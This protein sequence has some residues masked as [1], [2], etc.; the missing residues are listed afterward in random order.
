MSNTDQIFSQINGEGAG[1]W[2]RRRADRRSRRESRRVASGS[3]PCAPTVS[4]E[5]DVSLP[6][7]GRKRSARNGRSLGPA[8]KARRSSI[9]PPIEDCVAHRT[10]S[11]SLNGSELLKP[12]VSEDKP[13]STE[14]NTPALLARPSSSKSG[15]GFEGLLFPFDDRDFDYSPFSNSTA[16]ELV[17]S[18]HSLYSPNKSKTRNRRRKTKGGNSNAGSKRQRYELSS[19]TASISSLQAI[20]EA[21]AARSAPST[22]RPVAR[23]TLVFKSSPGS[24][25]NKTYP[26]R[27]RNKNAS[28]TSEER[29]RD[30]S[31]KR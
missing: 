15:H 30:S 7:T 12:S 21:V 5:L 24:K 29:F 25:L 17:D 8:K 1:E 23:P 27:N 20:K 16:T 6:T 31:G 4:A 19:P 26:L 18:D 28:S 9:K 13:K 2:S 11:K 10:R 14:L 3:L 22:R